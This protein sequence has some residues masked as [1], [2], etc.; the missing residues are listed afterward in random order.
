MIRAIPLNH[1]GGFY[2]YTVHFPKLQKLCNG[3]SGL[4]DY[5][6]SL[7]T[8]CPDAHFNNGPRSSSLKFSL[9]DVDLHQ[10]TGHP[11]SSYARAG[12]EQ[13]KDRFKQ[14]H[15]QVQN[16]LLEQ[17]GN[18][19][20]LEVPIW[21]NPS[22]MDGYNY[23]FKD[24]RPLTGHIDILK[25]EEGKIWIWD[26]KPKAHKEEYASTQVFFYAL[27]L[28]KRTGIPLEKFRCGYFDSSYAFVFEPRLGLI[29]RKSLS[30]F[31]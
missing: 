15:P 3:Y 23:L 17:D 6:G 2:M 21:L 20:A 12:L 8:D 27:M 10:V 22:E 7:F 19:V 18:T 5:L 14:A 24:T 16:F 30:E 25:I 9:N 11:M 26:Y 4:N 31:I 28:S 1:A 13:Y 29:K